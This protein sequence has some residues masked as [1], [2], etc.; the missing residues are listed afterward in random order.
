ME[1]TRIKDQIRELSVDV[2]IK[3]RMG[4]QVALSDRQM[5]IVE[6]LNAHQEVTMP[7]AR[8]LLPM[9][10]EDTILRDLK[11]LMG[12][13]VIIKRGSTKAAKYLLK[14]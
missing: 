14:K 9:V 11:Y 1:L 3:E 13:G 4:K 8:G 12:K 2:K 5:K 6:Y 10:S 7:G